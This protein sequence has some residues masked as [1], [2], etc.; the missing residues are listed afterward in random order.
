M[1]TNMVR[2]VRAPLT[3]TLCVCFA[4]ALTACGG[5]TEESADTATASQAD[6]SSAQAVDTTSSAQAINQRNLIAL[7]QP[8]Q[9]VAATGTMTVGWSA[10]TT[11]ADGLKMA[12]L[13]GYRVYYG[14]SSG[15]YTSTIDVPGATTLAYT[16][17]GLPT[18]TY[19]VVVKAY[20][21]SNNESS[22]SSEVSKAIR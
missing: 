14:T 11:S 19:Y 13:A 2:A 12:D 22:A 17:S 8:V 1:R 20:D 6:A 16:I 18:N 7:P 15:N 3:M 5:G 4:A 21:S 9:P 10:P